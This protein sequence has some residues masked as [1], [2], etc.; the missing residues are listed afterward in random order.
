V[1]Q[2]G[3]PVVEVY[4]SMVYGNMVLMVLQVTGVPLSHDGK[5]QAIDW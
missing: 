5:L 3:P 1:F 2:V 4:T